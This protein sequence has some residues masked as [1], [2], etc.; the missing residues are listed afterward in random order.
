MEIIRASN[1][2]EV[3]EHVKKYVDLFSCFS[4]KGDK[5]DLMRDD[6][7]SGTVNYLILEGYQKHGYVRIF[8]LDLFQ[9]N[10]FRKEN[11]I[12][13][14]DIMVP[15][16]L[17]DRLE[18]LQEYLLDEGY[19]KFYLNKDISWVDNYFENSPVEHKRLIL[20]ELNVMKHFEEG[21]RNYDLVDL[22]KHDFY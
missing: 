2:G 14:L 1:F 21:D 7:S 18:D 6:F 9:N 3:Y 12:G 17:Q 22:L 20:P 8:E 10:H 16:N 4:F 11:R 15:R 5:F 19:D 13:L